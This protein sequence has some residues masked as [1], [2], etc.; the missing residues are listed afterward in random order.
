MNIP[1]KESEEKIALNRYRALLKV[2]RATSQD[3]KRLIRKAFQIA[4]EAHKGMVRRSGEPY[5]VHPVEVAIIAAGEIGLGTTSVVCALLH[6]VV[7]DTDYTLS[8]IEGLFGKKVARIID[9]LTK[10]SGI[11]DHS[12]SSLQ[13]ENFRK[14]L[15]TLSDDVRVI[16]IKLADRLHNM[17]TLDAMPLEK[18]MKVAGETSYLFAPLAHRLGLYAIKSELEDLSMK[19]MEPEIYNTIVKKLEETEEE[20]KRFINRFIAPIKKALKEEG[21]KHS[22]VS[23][24]KSIHSIWQK[25]KRKTIPLEE[26]YDIFAVRIIIDTAFEKEK[27]DCWRVYALITDFYMPKQDRLRDWISIPKANGY[28]ALH[29]TVMSNDGKWVEIQIRTQRMDEIAEK[30]FAAHWKYKYDDK[31]SGLT[32]WLNKIRELLLNPDSD[33]LDFLDE[34]KLNLFADE[35]YLFTP[36]GDVKSLPVN[37]SVLDF[38]YYIHSEIGHHCIGAKVNQKLVPIG[39]KLKS[40]DQIEVITSKVQE[41][42]EEWLEYCVTARAKS[43]IKAAIKEKKK[44][45]VEKGRNRLTDILKQLKIDTDPMPEKELME[46]FD[47]KSHVDFYYKFATNDIGIDEVKDYQLKNEKRSWLRYLRKPFGKQSKFIE[48]S[49][50]E[51]SL[52]QIIQEQLKEKPEELLLGENTDEIVYSIEDCCNPIPGDDVIGFLSGIRGIAI[53]RVSCPKA[54]ELMSTYGNRIVK[55]KWAGNQSIAFLT[56][57][58]FDGVDKLGLVNSITKVIS[59]EL[60]INIRSLNI[61]T[62][63]GLSE[64]TAML[65]VQ[66]TNHLKNMIKKIKKID[67]VQNVYRIP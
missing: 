60:N 29:T 23:R 37:A 53:H 18:K 25:T 58:R 67:G 4:A 15:L 35:I 34:F 62:H 8:D 30:G 12:T 41:P 13:A 5:I 33:A 19:Y 48:K 1:D 3:D 6:D 26:V 52:H 54:V 32:E 20:R 11:F 16:L 65:Y 43:Q 21:I 42:N 27:A 64:G 51:S 57:I 44:R 61:N 55:V 49:D 31:E 28:E 10:I 63:N 40:G 39:Y 14:M 59:E 56:G 2:I 47:I 22:I 24:T 38:A 9:G 66:D 7:E 36:K 50:H 45:L 17:R 46:H